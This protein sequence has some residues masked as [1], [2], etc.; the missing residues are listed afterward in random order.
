MRQCYPRDVLVLHSQHVLIPLLQIRQFYFPRCVNSTFRNVLNL[1]FGMCKFYIVNR[2]YPTS[3]GAL[4]LLFEMMQI[5][6]QRCGNSIGT[7]G[8]MLGHPP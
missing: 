8:G 4:V 7:S 5:D 1:R 6:F 3:P 2:A